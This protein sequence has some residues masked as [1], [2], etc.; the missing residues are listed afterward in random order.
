MKTGDAAP[1]HQ[2]MLGIHIVSYA[3]SQRHCT[4]FHGVKT[5]VVAPK[6]AVKLEISIDHLIE[7]FAQSSSHTCSSIAVVLGL[8]NNINVVVTYFEIEKE[9][10][11]CVLQ[12]EKVKL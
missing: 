7:N 5:G 10:K 2:S 6:T 4:V 11:S 3:S 9:A 12:K 1:N 8:I